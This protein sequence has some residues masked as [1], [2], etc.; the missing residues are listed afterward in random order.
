M[1]VM[2]TKPG[3]LFCVKQHPT[4]DVVPCWSREPV[5]EHL[6]YR[7]LGML[8]AGSVVIFLGKSKTAGQVQ[9]VHCRYKTIFMEVLTEFGVGIVHIS[10]IEK[11]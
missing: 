3:T 8:T 5:D 6:S 2:F 9:Q 10:F 4:S 1:P 11:L 7:A